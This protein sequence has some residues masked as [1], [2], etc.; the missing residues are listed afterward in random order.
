MIFEVRNHIH[1]RID[2][3]YS[4]I[5]TNNHM[6]RWEDRFNFVSVKIKFSNDSDITLDE[7]TTKNYHKSI[8]QRWEQEY[9]DDWYTVVMDKK[10][11]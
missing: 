11:K 9:P 5:T 1:R 6:N 10:N 7:E 4:I 8:L 3:E 2:R